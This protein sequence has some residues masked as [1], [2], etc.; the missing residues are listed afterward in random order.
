MQRVVYRCHR[1]RVLLTGSDLTS[2]RL[3]LGINLLQEKKLLSD[4]GIPNEGALQTATSNAARA[5]GLQRMIGT[6]DKASVPI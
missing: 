2:H 6:V 3:V 1:Q 4:T 5:R